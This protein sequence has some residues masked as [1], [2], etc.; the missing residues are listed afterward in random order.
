VPAPLSTAIR[1]AADLGP[2]GAGTEVYLTLGLR[3]RHPDLLASL[4]ASGHAVSSAAYAA[5]FGP[6]PALAHKAVSVL[7]LAGFR[8]AWRPGSDL[9]AADGPAPAAALLLG[10]GIENYRLANGTTF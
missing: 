5:E 7:A 9:I 8:A 2:A 6:A 4:L 3:V 10:I 1:R